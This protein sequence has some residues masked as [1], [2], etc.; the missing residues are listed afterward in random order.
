PN[1]NSI[2]GKHRDKLSMFS[3]DCQGWLCITIDKTAEAQIKLQH[4]EDH[5]PYCV[6]SLTERCGKPR[7]KGKT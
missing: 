6:I 7:D 5:V 3:F 1:K 2:T 4:K